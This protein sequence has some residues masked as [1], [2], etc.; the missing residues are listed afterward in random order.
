[1]K[2]HKVTLIV[3]DHDE[4]GADGVASALEN[5]RYANRCISPDVIKVETVDCGEWS[6]DHP[7]NNR[8]TKPAEINRLFNTV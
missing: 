6:D 1:M 8:I 7:L 3:I 5:A 2:V 4:L